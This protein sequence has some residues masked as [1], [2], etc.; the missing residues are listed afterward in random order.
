MAAFSAGEQVFR[1]PLE[2]RVNRIGVLRLR[3]CNLGRHGQVVLVEDFV[4]TVCEGGNRD[5]EPGFVGEVL[6]E[7]VD[8]G[9]DVMLLEV[10]D[11]LLH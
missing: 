10:R 6:F 1:D 11:Q 2:Q 5:N 9:L 8:S 4:L 7:H 3:L